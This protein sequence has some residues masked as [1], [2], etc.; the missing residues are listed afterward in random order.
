MYLSKDFFKKDEAFNAL[1]FKAY[2][3]E[4]YA[5]IHGDTA[6]KKNTVEKV[7]II[8]LETFLENDHCSCVNRMK[9]NETQHKV[10][11]FAASY[12]AYLSLEKE[13]KKL[14]GS[15]PTETTPPDFAKY[16]YLQNLI[17]LDVFA[18]R[19]RYQGESSFE[20]ASSYAQSQKT[21][22]IAKE[23]CK[24]SVREFKTILK[25]WN[26][27]FDTIT[28]VKDLGYYTLTNN[29]GFEGK[30]DPASGFDNAHEPDLNFDE[31]YN[32]EEVGI[33][34]GL[35]L[36]LR[37]VRQYW[38]GKA[39][40]AALKQIGIDLDAYDSFTTIILPVIISKAAFGGYHA[41]HTH[42]KFTPEQQEIFLTLSN[43]NP[44]EPFQQH[45]DIAKSI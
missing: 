39:L 10:E 12:E 40:Y 5:P 21:H 2:I 29:D 27:Y 33:K 13:L 20:R 37:N 41:H 4:N 15:V 18:M 28:K 35:W 22:P 25:Q 23:L 38:G 31:L 30:Y 43:D 42:A 3:P 8:S 44:I 9:M 7:S 17:N 16:S 24:Q 26:A 32:S 14:R 1:E 34:K 19:R 45:I 6:C 11:D 36:D